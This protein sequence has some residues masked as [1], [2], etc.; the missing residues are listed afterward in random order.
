MRGIGQRKGTCLFGFAI[1]QISSWPLPLSTVLLF[2]FPS[3][4]S[5]SIFPMLKS[6]P[7]QTHSPI[8]CSAGWCKCVTFPSNPSTLSCHHP[9]LSFPP[10]IWC[11]WFPRFPSFLLRTVAAFLLLSRRLCLVGRVV[12]PP[13]VAT[14]WWLQPAG[15]GSAVGTEGKQALC[16]CA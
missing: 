3:L 7:F 6:R 16:L 9:S 5:L 11:P 15:V 13:R 2:V 4:F 12:S 14:G 8:F 10:A 1:L